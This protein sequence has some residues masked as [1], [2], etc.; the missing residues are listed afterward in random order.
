MSLRFNPPWYTM[1]EDSPLPPFYFFLAAPWHMGVPRPGIRTN[2]SCGL[3][4]ILNSLCQARDQT[5]VPALQRCHPSHCTTV[6]TPISL[7]LKA[8]YYSIV[9]TCHIFFIYSSFNGHL[10][11]FHILA[12]VNNA[13]MNMEVQI[14]LKILLWIILH[15]YPGARLLDHMVAIFWGTSIL[16]L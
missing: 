1:W 5:C 12:I 11:C 6:G 9:Y 10:R 2:C 15:I 16:F 13:E 3:H 4:Q 14:S 8:A 7:F